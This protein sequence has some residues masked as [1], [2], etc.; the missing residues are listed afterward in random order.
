MLL[1]FTD[2]IENYM[3]QTVS[4][5][6]VKN[7]KFHHPSEAH[8]CEK[9][10]QGQKWTHVRVE[11]KTGFVQQ[12]AYAFSRAVLCRRAQQ[13]RGRLLHVVQ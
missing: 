4:I 1:K 6:S 8:S 2:L 9:E 3:Q 10:K 11:Q 13:L 12:A 7:W 5:S